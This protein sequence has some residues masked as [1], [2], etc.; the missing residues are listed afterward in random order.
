M[1][2]NVKCENVQHWLTLLPAS[3]TAVWTGIFFYK[4]QQSKNKQ[5]MEQ[6][7]KIEEKP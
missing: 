6:I 3:V 1:F 2:Y 7:K 4:Q 5:I